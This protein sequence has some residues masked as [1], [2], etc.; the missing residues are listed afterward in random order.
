MAHPQRQ[1]AAE[2]G[3]G[4]MM[5]FPPGPPFGGFGRNAGRSVLEDDSGFNLVAMLSA[6]SGTA[7]L[8]L[9]TFLEEAVDGQG[10]RMHG[11]GRDLFVTHDSRWMSMENGEG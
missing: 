2:P 9:R 8:S 5:V 11:G 10:G 4:D 7:H 6:G 3:D 1:I